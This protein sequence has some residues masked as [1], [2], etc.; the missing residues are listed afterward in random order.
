MRGTRGVWLRQGKMSK[1][2]LLWKDR[3]KVGE[4]SAAL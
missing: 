3:N 1:R 4:V 2:V